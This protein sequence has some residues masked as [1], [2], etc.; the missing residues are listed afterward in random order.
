MLGVE[1]LKTR[2]FASAV[3]SLE[4]A[5]LLLPRDAVDRSNLGFALAS[6]R[7]YDRA[8]QELRR[9]IALDSSDLTTRQLLDAVLAASARETG[10]AS[11]KQ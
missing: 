10:R 1:Y 2:Q 7:Q 4:E 5:V 8:E 3:T 6:L 9:A 11:S